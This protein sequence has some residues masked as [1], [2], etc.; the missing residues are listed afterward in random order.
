[1]SSN[2]QYYTNDCLLRVSMK[3]NIDAVQANNICCNK[4]ERN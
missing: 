4:R 1:M 3:T 2:I